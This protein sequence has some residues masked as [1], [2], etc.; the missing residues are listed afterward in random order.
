MNSELNATN[1]EVSAS[2]LIGSYN[3]QWDVVL[4]GDMFYDSEFVDVISDWIKVLVRKGITLYVGD[5]DRLPF[6][7]HPLKYRLKLCAE[8]QLSENSKFE[9][10]GLST[11]NVWSYSRLRKDKPN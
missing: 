10:N 6:M 9:N 1:I 5:P 7:N 2:N 4:L 3:S 11:G 8:Y